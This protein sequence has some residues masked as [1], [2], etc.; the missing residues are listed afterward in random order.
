MKF[1]KSKGYRTY[2]D[3]KGNT[4]FT[5]RRVMEKKLGGSIPKG[6]V[7]HHLNE[8][9]LDNRPANLVAMR[10]DIHARHHRLAEQGRTVCFR[11]GHEGHVAADC[12]ASRDWK[13]K[14]LKKE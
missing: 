9:K 7:V 1:G 6:M 10:G 12:Y 2:T 13:R 14:P 11:C 3:R 8:D 5:H 4:E